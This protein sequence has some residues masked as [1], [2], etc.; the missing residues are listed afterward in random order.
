MR[1]RRLLVNHFA[2]LLACLAGSAL[3]MLP[4]LA[5][6]PDDCRSAAASVPEGPRPLTDAGTRNLVAFTRLLGYV[7]HFHP[8]DQ[9]AAADW[10][11]LA[12][13]GMR[14][15][16]PCAGPEQVAKALEA[17]FRK[18]A[19][20]VQVFAGGMQPPP[21]AGLTPPAGAQNLKLVSWRHV[22]AGQVTTKDRPNIYK[23]ERL[24]VTAPNTAP[25]GSEPDQIYTADLGAGLTARVPLK[26][27]ADGNGTLPRGRAPMPE[28]SPRLLLA[29]GTEPSSGND[30][31]TRLAAVALAWNVFQHF[32]PYFDVVE[33]DWPQ[34]LTMALASAAADKDERAFLDTLR[35]LVAALHDGHGGVY[36]RSA[37]LTHALP[38]AWTMVDN[39]LVI[40]RTIG[41]GA[42]A[43]L[44]AGDVV[45]AID[46]EPT[47]A[48][49]S[50]LRALTSAATPQWARSYI[51][52]VH[53]HLG[54]RDSAMRLKVQSPGA[55]QRE[56]V[57]HRT[58]S[59][60]ETK[61]LLP[62]TVA[63]L[64]PGI[65]YFDI[66][67]ASTDDLDAA[68]P[69]LSEA[70]SV[71][72]DLRGYPWKTNDFLHY[73]SDQ[74]L[75]SQI[76]Q[77]PIVTKPDRLSVEYDTSGR[78]ELLPFEPQI[79]GRIIFMTGGG[80]ISNA[81]SVMGIIEAYRLADIVG[82]T[83]AGTNG[84]INPFA[85]PGR[86]VLSWTGMR[87]LK[88]DGTRHHGV[89]I[90]P[91]HPVSRTIKG[92]AEGRDEVLEKALELARMPRQ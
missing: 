21:P 43:G 9:A 56:V 92:I 82:E 49:M 62:S 19:P 48:A 23:S 34:A 54:P 13:E 64:E 35:R 20:T 85:V 47:D 45:L 80:A 37:P 17:F 58:V 79:K 12:V 60:D 32:Y 63:E 89:G 74:A 51:L 4:A 36:H 1:R 42:A 81:E 29:T 69:K 88:H 77:T 8:S 30:R 90:S 40:T 3:F 39:K 71:I 52:S 59:P 31:A 86:Y 73:L 55:A 38:L 83:T 67:R 15:I 33:T 66:D 18:V 25:L 28:P 5:Q 50:R 41:E 44:K 27:Y 78:W 91:T 72:F 61:E 24:S 6:A 76:W 46:G 70:K 10:D 65:F 53:L 2:L 87:V 22:G 7:R 57:L 26:L 75:E 16:E 11:S 84:N 68:L 14:R